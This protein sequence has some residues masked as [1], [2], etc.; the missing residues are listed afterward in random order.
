MRPRSYPK[1]GLKKENETIKELRALVRQQQKEIDNLR[2][3]LE[4]VVKPVRERK[5][6]IVKHK[7]QTHEEWRIDFLR[8]LRKDLN[9]K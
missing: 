8:R 6:H 3:E 2:N 5:T 7:H 9:D 4:N 1:E